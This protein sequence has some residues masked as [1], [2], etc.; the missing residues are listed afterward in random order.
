MDSVTDCCI[1]D[2]IV[3]ADPRIMA[4]QT[5]PTIP[6]TLV[7]ALRLAKTYDQWKTAMLAI[8]VEFINGVPQETMLMVEGYK[9]PR[10]FIDWLPVEL[11]LL[12]EAEEAGNWKLVAK[13]LKPRPGL[14]EGKCQ[15]RG[16]E[17]GLAL[18]QR[19][20]EKI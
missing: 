17:E 6:S 3:Q 10:K 19:L 18:V 16:D 12:K 1:D 7:D 4:T 15:D 9:Q 14:H 5:F 2:F 11:S 13:L 20:S 8:G